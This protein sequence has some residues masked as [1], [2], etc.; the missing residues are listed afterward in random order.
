MARN[1]AQEFSANDLRSHHYPAFGGCFFQQLRVSVRRD[2][3]RIDCKP[4]ATNQAGSNAGLNDMREHPAQRIAGAEP[5]MTSTGKHRVIRD[6][7]LDREPTKRAIGEVHLYF[8]AYRSFRANREH[9]TDDEHP[10]DSS[11]YRRP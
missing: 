4:L 11:F 2:Q 8:P 5:L 10:D 6:F 9:L 7:V 3:A 1:F